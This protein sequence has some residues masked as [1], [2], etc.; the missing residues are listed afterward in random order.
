MGIGG[1]KG[2]E[3]G[4]ELMEMG[5]EEGAI[6]EKKGEEKEPSVE[7]K[8]EKT[9]E[10]VSAV[11]LG[12]T[13]LLSTLSS[14]LPSAEVSR[15]S[16]NKYYHNA[17]FTLL[18]PSEANKNAKILSNMGID[19]TV[20]EMERVSRVFLY[21]VTN[22]MRYINDTEDSLMNLGAFSSFPSF[23]L[24]LSPSLFSLL[25]TPHH[26]CNKPTHP[27]KCPSRYFYW[28]HAVWLQRKVCEALCRE[29]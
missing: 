14:P 22:F 12:K 16:C 4:E 29:T 3:G 23:S 26:H 11:D 17:V 8:G 15:K 7:E 27:R 21:D 18:I 6:E 28:L 19:I 13:D 2:V 1:E 9:D 5:P 20:G 24:L 10:A 25:S